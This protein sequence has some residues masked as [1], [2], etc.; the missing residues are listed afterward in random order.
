LSILESP[1]V[2]FFNKSNRSTAPV[3]LA[4]SSGTAVVVVV[5][6]KITV[7]VV[8]VVDTDVAVVISFK[9][10]SSITFRLVNFS[11]IARIAWLD[12]SEFSV[13]V[14]TLDCVVVVAS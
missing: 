2:E 4:T 12:S 9:L 14:T 7:V 8:S 10:S 3:A 6:V 13:L 5:V 11:A 1:P